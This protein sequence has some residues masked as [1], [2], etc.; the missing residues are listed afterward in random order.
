MRRDLLAL[1]IFLLF[2]GLVF[3]SGSRVVVKPEPF[4]K[5]VAVED[6]TVEEPASILFVQGSLTHG[7]KYRVYFELAPPPPG[8][9]SADTIA[10]VNLTDPNGYME[11]YLI[12]IERDEMGLLRVTESFPGGVANYNGTYKVSAEVPKIFG[13]TFKSLSIQKIELV[14]KEPQYPYGFLLPV[15]IAILLGGVAI[16]LLGAKISRRKRIRYKRLL[17]KH[18]RPLHKRKG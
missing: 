3:I 2:L 4:E 10:Q 13:V 17:H 11:S 7:D 1:G 18:K 8:P 5:W 9:F 12:P 15:G 16:S 14:E 6:T